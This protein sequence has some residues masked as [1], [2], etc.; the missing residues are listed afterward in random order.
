MEDLKLRWLR[1]ARGA[2]LVI[3]GAAVVA[4]LPVAAAA[5]STD[6]GGLAALVTQVQALVDQTSANTSDIVTLKAEVSTL[7]T[8]E[9][10]QAS[11]IATQGQEIAALQ[12]NSTGATDDDSSVLNQAKAYADQGD[13]TTASSVSSAIYDAALAAGSSDPF[14]A[15]IINQG[16]LGG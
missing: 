9:N 4:L 14:A 6:A 8:T 2:R 10:A 15:V 3:A 13:S 11:L 5:S 16:G 7:T 12:A 1:H